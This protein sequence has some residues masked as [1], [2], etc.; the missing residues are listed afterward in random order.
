[1]AISDQVILFNGDGFNYRGVIS[2]LSK[3][4]L[5]VDIQDKQETTNESPLCIHLLQPLCKSDKMDWCLQKATELGV[6]IITPF[7]SSRVNINIPANRLDKKM[8]HWYSVIES[9]CE[10]SGRASIPKINIPI[11]FNDAITSSPSDIVKIIAIPDIENSEYT[12][13]DSP[14]SQCICAI[15]PEGGFD[16][17][18]VAF[19][20]SMGFSSLQ[21]GPRILRLETAVIS[22][23]T[24]CQSRWGDFR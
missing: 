14:I 12:Y 6:N 23:V 20:K 7:I 3:K 13:T 2:E 9:A 22:I 17:N 4:T 18:E 24:L 19:A 11:A 1:M 10:Q 21:I 5:C 8:A 16:A 15:G